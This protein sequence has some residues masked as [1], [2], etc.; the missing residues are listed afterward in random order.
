MEQS[1]YD[2][3]VIGAGAVG[4][5]VAREL[6]RFSLSVCVLERCEDVCSGTTKAN[7]AIVHAGFDAVPGTLKA[8]FNVEGSVMMPE[9]SEELDFRFRRCGSMVVCLEGQD[10]DLLRRLCDQGEKNGVEGLRIISGDEARRLE[11]NLSE[12]VTAALLAPTGGIVCPFEM[13]AAFYENAIENGAEFRF[14]E[15]V[16]SVERVSEGFRVL[17]GGLDVRC[18]YV[19]NAAG[20]FAGEIHGMVCADKLEIVP[21]RGEY[22]LLD[23][24]A[25]THTARTI[26]GLPGKSG[27]GVLVTPTVHGN[28]LIGPTAEDIED[29]LDTSTTSTGLETVRARSAEMVRDIPYSAVI[30]S[31]AGVRAHEKGGDFIVGESA[32]GFFDA[33]GIE[34]PGLTAAPA[35]GRYLAGLVAERAGAR[36]KENFVPTRRGI[37]RPAELTPG[38]RAE[39]IAADP[40][41]GSIVCRCEGVSEG[42]IV[43]AVRRGARSLDGVKRRVRA[44]MGRCQGGFC[45]P[46][47]MEIL[48]RELGVPM[49][50][51]RKNVKGSELLTGEMEERG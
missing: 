25:G 34:S 43:E 17:T 12:N 9:L 10:G 50:Q 35:I 8:R 36:E 18:G 51:I 24:S 22:M 21:R 42:E 39:L 49:T 23:K 48:S 20:T 26:F 37:P 46:R 41:Y 6:S 7:S 40:L 44:G 16:R 28:L 19:V 13:T 2:V 32:E 33:A 14:G 45:T 1:R 3:I 38:R 4:C 31:F 30:T 29:P 11:P 47:V 15:E 5:A 27:K